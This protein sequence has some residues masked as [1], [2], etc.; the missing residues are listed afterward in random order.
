[1]ALLTQ[2]EVEQ[3]LSNELSEWTREGDSITRSVTAD[4]FVEGIRLVSASQR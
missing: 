4:S 2:Q 1:M 3:A